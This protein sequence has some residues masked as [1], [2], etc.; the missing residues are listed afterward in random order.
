MNYDRPVCAREKGFTLV[1]MLAVMAIMSIVMALAAPNFASFASNQRLRGAS[2][3]LVTTLLTARSEAIKRN[4]E[5]TVSATVLGGSANWGR[6]WTA[7]AGGQQIER[8]EVVSDF[9]DGST[10]PTAIVFDGSG[11]ITAA[12]GASIQ[13]RDGRGD[14]TVAPRCISIDL[15]GRPQASVGACS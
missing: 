10:S 13:L 7:T 5:V 3:D 6:G 11:R 14:S 9:I 2:S 1:E 8:K 4:A 15:A 12:G